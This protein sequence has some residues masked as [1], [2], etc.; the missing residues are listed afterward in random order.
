VVAAV[1]GGDDLA[2]AEVDRD[3]AVDPGPGRVVLEGD[4]VAGRDRGQ[5]DC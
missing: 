4:D 2:A 3:V 1:G 5:V